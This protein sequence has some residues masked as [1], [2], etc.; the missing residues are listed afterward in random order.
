VKLCNNWIR[1]RASEM[2]AKR[3]TTTSSR[4]GQGV[5]V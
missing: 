1:A 4:E 2:A 5:V 3:E